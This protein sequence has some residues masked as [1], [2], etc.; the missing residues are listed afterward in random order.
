MRGRHCTAVRLVSWLNGPVRD[1][2]G[3]NL[4]LRNLLPWPRLYHVRKWLPFPN[5]STYRAYCACNSLKGSLSPGNGLK[6]RVYRKRRAGRRVR[7]KEWVGEVRKTDQELTVRN[8]GEAPGEK[9][10]HRVQESG[11]V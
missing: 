11:N 3:C 7:V 6:A 8:V 1:E 2:Q 4:I 5:S 10:N 9:Q